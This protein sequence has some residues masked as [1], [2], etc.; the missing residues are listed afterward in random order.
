MTATETI[1]LAGLIAGVLDIT[2]TSVLFVL[3]G[4]S[5]ERLY[6]VVASGVLGQAAFA[7]GKKTAAIGLCFHFAIALIFAAAYFMISR[8]LRILVERP[9]IYGALY[10]ALVHIVMSWIVVPMSAAPKREF[11]LKAFSIQLLIHI[12]FVG[13]PIAL[14]ISHFSR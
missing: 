10:G 11:S 12:C 13:L 14:T 8:D 6:Q 9:A 7:G 4:L 3:Q 1:L 2:A 5:L